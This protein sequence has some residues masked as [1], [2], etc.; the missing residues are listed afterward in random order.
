[1]LAS[2][3]RFAFQGSK[4]RGTLVPHRAVFAKKA[5]IPIKYFNPSQNSNILSRSFYSSKFF[6][7][8]DKKKTITLDP[9]YQ[10][11]KSTA[12]LEQSR[13]SLSTMTKSVVSPTPCS[14]QAPRTVVRGPEDLES[15]KANISKLLEQEIETVKE[16][17]LAV[18]IHSDVT[19]QFL[20]KT[21]YEIT[22]GKEGEVSLKRTQGNQTITVVFNRNEPSESQEFEQ[23]EEDAEGSAK[24]NEELVSK[25]EASAGAIPVKQSVQIEVAFNDKKGKWVL[26]GFAGKDN[27]L[28]IEDM[29]I[30]PSAE[31]ATSSEQ[32][33][34]AIPFESLSD[35]LQDRIYD[36]LDEVAV[37]DQLAHFVK[38][39]TAECETKSAVKFLENLKD[40]MKS[41]PPKS[42]DA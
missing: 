22:D 2:T 24:E 19:K 42:E 15:I 38:Y 20:A 1:M 25:D 35:E 4:I 17:A 32:S 40:L 10:G 6:L 7:D 39:Y 11:K 29:S 41:T 12:T 30:A 27:R 16:E 21:K 18:E 37:D 28:Y 13:P 26:G 14:S 34:E 3:A 33:L 9:K 5:N 23:M 8:D 36:Y 31:E